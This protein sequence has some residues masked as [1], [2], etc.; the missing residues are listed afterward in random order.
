MVVTMVSSDCTMNVQSND[1]GE[2]KMAYNATA[3]N[4][5][6]KKEHYKRIPV[7]IDKAYYSDVLVPAAEARGIGIS[8]YIKEAI[9][10]KIEREST[11]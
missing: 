9:R 7:E 3:Y 2:K 4:N 5:S 6:Y 8:T 10:E 1:E 11:R